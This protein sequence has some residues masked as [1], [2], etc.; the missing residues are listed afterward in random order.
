[1]SPSEATGRLSPG[2]APSRRRPPRA[3]GGERRARAHH[4]SRALQLG[5]R[6]QA[7]LPPVHRGY[8]SR[9][10]SG[11]STTPDLAVDHL[12]F[13]WDG[14]APCYLANR[15]KGCSLSQDADP[16]EKG[17]AP[18]LSGHVPGLTK[19]VHPQFLQISDSSLSRFGH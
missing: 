9:T 5:G 18:R 3:A 13:L 8:C 17:A 12:I 10:L 1:M 2:V 15:V 14:N 11:G 4:P 6:K 16:V 7:F 19:T